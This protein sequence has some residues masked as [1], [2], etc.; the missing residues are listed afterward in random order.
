MLRKEPVQFVSNPDDEQQPR[1][2]R[3]QQQQPD[4]SS[5]AAPD[6]H[7]LASP[8]TARKRDGRRAHRQRVITTMTI[9]NSSVVRE[10]A[11]AMAIGTTTSAIQQRRDRMARDLFLPWFLCVDGTSAVVSI[12]HAMALWF[13]AATQE[14]CNAIFWM[15][16][17]LLQQ[18]M[19]R[20]RLRKRH[21]RRQPCPPKSLLRRHLRQQW[22]GLY[23][24]PPSERTKRLWLNQLTSSPPCSVAWLH[25][26]LKLHES[27]VS[28][29]STADS[30]PTA[31]DNHPLPSPVPISSSTTSPW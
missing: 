13:H 22:Y 15:D 3:Q 21:R 27:V 26:H 4:Y 25:D 18:V 8:A 31:D 24:C 11:A 9:G 28:L 5:R 1:R 12:K 14:R 19:I 23:P 2:G 20:A 7:D 29:A 17:T 6:M 16:L 30:T 10:A